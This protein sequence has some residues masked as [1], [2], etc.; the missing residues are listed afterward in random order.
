MIAPGTHDYEEEKY[1]GRIRWVKGPR[2]PFDARYGVLWNM[3]KVHRIIDEEAPD[4]LEGSSAWAGGQFA[5]RW[6][7]NAVRTL[8]FHQDQI[9]VIP[10]P[11][12]T[13]SYHGKKWTGSLRQFGHICGV[14]R[15]PMTQPLL[16]ENGS[17]T[18][19]MSLVYTTP[20]LCHSGSTS[21]SSRR[22]RDACASA[23]NSLRVVT[24]TRLHRS[25]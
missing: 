24:V 1:G 22:L 7:G 20:S 8:I 6:K 16:Q 4:I 12:L 14:F 18:D 2:M 15:N 5:A 11:I 21:R 25:F 3:K 9:A 19:W 17:A 23:L 10:T 13:D